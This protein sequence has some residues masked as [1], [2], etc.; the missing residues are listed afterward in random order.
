MQDFHLL[1]FVNRN[2][3]SY[4][5]GVSLMYRDS[6]DTSYDAEEMMLPPVDQLSEAFTKHIC[7]TDQKMKAREMVGDYLFEYP[8]GTFFQNNNSV[9]PLLVEHVRDLIKQSSKEHPVTH[10]VDAYCGAG[11][12]AVS[13]SHLFQKVS[14]IELSPSSIAAAKDNAVKNSI[15]SSKIS[16]AF[17]DA[18][19]IFSAVEEYPRSQTVIIIDP[20]R[21]GCDDNFIGQLLR[22]R[23]HSVVYV[24]CNV[25]TQ[26]RD[27]G[28][29]VRKTE[30]EPVGKRYRLESL[31]GFDLFPQTSHVES[32][33]LLCLY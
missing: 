9:M 15:P 10:L 26:A 14:G 8:A 13:L 33:A 4:K 3:F 17:G 25:H 1:I 6:L 24:S 23:C 2:I 19:E 7:V 30:N 28:S 16:F 29:I 5:K 22:F 20:P 27:I 12:F 11:L 31:R 32:V 18:G 21:K